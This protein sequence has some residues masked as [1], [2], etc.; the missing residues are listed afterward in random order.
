MVSLI[1]DINHYEMWA[2]GEMRGDGK[3]KELRENMPL[4]SP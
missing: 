1:N 3:T 2:I 4:F